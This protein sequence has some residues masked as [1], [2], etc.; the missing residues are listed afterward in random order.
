METVDRLA[1]DLERVRIFLEEK[2]AEPEILAAYDGI[3]QECTAMIGERLTAGGMETTAEI[4]G[5][6]RSTWWYVCRE[7]YTVID[8]HDHYCRQCGRRILWK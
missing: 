6:G 7:C 2:K 3:R 5:D 4:G 8:Y 1:E